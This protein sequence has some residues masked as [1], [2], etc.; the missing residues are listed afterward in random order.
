VPDVETNGVFI[1]NKKRKIAVGRIS[2]LLVTNILGKKTSLPDRNPYSSLEGKE[3][4]GVRKVKSKYFF[5]FCCFF[6]LYPSLVQAQPIVPATDGTGTVVTP[7]GDRL[8]ITGG[9][10]STN[11]ANLFHSFSQF[12]LNPNQTANFLSNPAIQNILTRVT[13]GDPSVINGLIQVTG[14]NSNLFIMNPAGIL[15]GPNASLNIPASFTATTATGIGVGNQWFNAIGSNNYETLVGTPSSFTF[16]TSQPPG[17]I[18]NAGNLAV[19]Q[20]Q[21][22][23]LVGGTV[24]STGTLAA[25][26]GNITVTAVPGES[27][28]RISQQGHLLSL[29]IQP[30]EKLINPLSLPQLLTGSG[31]NTGLIVNNAGQAVLANS[32][33]PVANGDVVAKNV[34]SQ[35]ATLSAQHN[36]T[37]VESQLRTTGDM[38]LLAQN[39]VRVRDSA[40]NPFLAQAGGNLYIQGNQSI[41]ILA[42]NHPQTPFTSNGQLSLV[43]NGNVSGD[44]HFA[45]SG[46]SVLNL[47][48]TPGNF[49]SLYDP[50]ISSIGESSLV[51][52]QVW[53]SRWSPQGASLVE[54]S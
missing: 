27:T 51:I 3:E 54:I 33:L 37:L 52:T 5:L 6:F 46:F 22:L 24:A 4:N 1:L 35:T 38:N 19:A 8:D 31:Q 13:G 25:P 20:G 41:D 30:S 32:G 53:H 36:L 14:G 7:S 40:A 21:S 29:E 26:G 45:S 48:G 11:G 34:T 49:V 47:A 16:A 28:L 9:Q 50:I 18:V 17:A 15:F 42:L 23:S 10:T 39:T 2:Y 12:G 43:S 44:A